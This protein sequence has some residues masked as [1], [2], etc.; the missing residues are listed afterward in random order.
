VVYFVMN[1]IVVPLSAIPRGPF[2][3]GLAA[4]LVVIHMFCVGLP[5]ALATAR[6]VDR[7][8]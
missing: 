4:T 3:P 1:W 7:K 5:I 8:V 6:F 2:R